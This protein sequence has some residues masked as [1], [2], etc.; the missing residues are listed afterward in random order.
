MRGAGL[1]PPLGRV[2]QGCPAR[3]TPSRGRATGL[4]GA[5]PDRSSG[6]IET[7]DGLFRHSAG[8]RLC[9]LQ[10]VRPRSRRRDPA[11]LNVD[12]TATKRF[13]KWELGPVGYYSSDPVPGYLRQ[14]QF[15]MGGL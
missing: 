2:S 4:P 8:G 6:L 10:G 3:P 11:R 14:S 7:I 5:V 12:L 15:A 1:L 9:R 13:G